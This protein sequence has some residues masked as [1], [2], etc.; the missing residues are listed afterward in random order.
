MNDLPLEQGDCGV[1]DSERSTVLAGYRHSHGMELGMVNPEWGYWPSF[2]KTWRPDHPLFRTL[3]EMA[4]LTEVGGG[5]LMLIPQTRA[6]GALAILVSFVFIATQIRLGFLCEM[7]IVCCL[8]FLGGSG[9]E[10]V[11][12]SSSAISA[13]IDSTSPS[14]SVS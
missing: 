11:A 2:W 1:P 13:W 4:W 9:I 7:V 6:L 5:A 14:S 8:L 3:D 10:P 12:A